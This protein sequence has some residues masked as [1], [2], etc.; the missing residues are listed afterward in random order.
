MA[1]ATDILA[2]EAQPASPAAP[3]GRLATERLLAFVSPAFPIGAVSLPLTIYLPVYYSGYVGLSLS[4][5]GFA[6]FIVR[7]L[8]IGFDPVMG[9][10]IDRTRSPWGQNRPWMLAGGLMVVLSTLML[11][12]AEPGSTVGRLVAGLA[13]LYAGTSI[14]AIAQSAWAARLATGYNERGYLY[15]WLQVGASAG[16]FVLLGLPMAGAALGGDKPGQDIHIM[17]LAL[18]V[19][20]PLSLAW[21]LWRVLEPP[22]PPAHAG[23]DDRVRM[24]DYLRLLAQP[25]IRRLVVA[26]LLVN[27]GVAT[28][29]T[30]FLFFWRAARG[31]SG[32]QSNLII[33]TYFFAAL[34]SVPLWARLVRV[35]GKHRAFILAGMG[36]VL[37]MPVM[38]FLPR[39][40]IE[41]VMPVFAGVGLTFAAS[42]FLIRSMAADA[43]DEWRLKSGVDRLGQI[44]ALLASTTKVGSALAVG[45]T[46]RVLDVVGFKAKAGAANTPSA[47]HALELIYVGAP[48]FMTF[49]GLLAILG[50]RLDR[51]AHGKVQAALAARDAEAG[52]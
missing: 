16:T 29:S 24:G 19:A 4:V 40:H 30:L 41:V 48:A 47:L 20:M 6:F 2:D 13:I 27:F 9:W 38:A 25:N 44:Y 34:V 52:R 36:Y 14:V 49:L 31:Y 11:F 12:L 8:D 43:N 10:V 15:A 23:A 28:S 3:H 21:A 42:N 39:G 5:V 50:Y 35:L 18:A 51:E 45:V 7:T 46:F 26:D 1:T 17:G 22:V 37:L 33:L 32:P